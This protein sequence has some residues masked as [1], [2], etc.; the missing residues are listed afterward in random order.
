MTKLS[1][2]DNEAFQLSDTLIEKPGLWSQS[3]PVSSDSPVLSF[4]KFRAF[5]RAVT[6]YR[7]IVHLL[8]LGQWED[9]LILLRSLYELNVNIS[10][11]DYS[12]ERDHAVKK[13]VRFGKFQQ[14]RMEQRRIEDQHRDESSK[15]HPSV[16]AIAECEQNLAAIASLLD[17]DFA[18]FRDS[19]GKWQ[20]S[21]SGVSVE[22]LAQ[23]LAKK[24]G[25]QRGQSD[26]YVFRLGSL[27]THNAPG[28]LFFRLRQPEPGYWN[29][30]R[31]ALDEAGHDGLRQFLYEAS[32]CFVDIV[33]LTA[34]SIRGYEQQWFDNALRL[35]AKFT[36]E[37]N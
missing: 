17:R 5:D 7:S 2:E 35:L 24:T 18:E 16:Q 34:E 28:S 29:E 36:K 23:H 14:L 27:F 37:K 6:Q 11:I 32:V 1:F 8:K 15:L 22:T 20:E 33:G 19:R 9:A 12:S 13:F 21:W 10:E 31:A 25:G 4:V 30:F 3:V 26:Y